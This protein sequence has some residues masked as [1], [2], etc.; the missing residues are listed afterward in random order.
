MFKRR[1][2]HNLEDDSHQDDKVRE[3]ESAIGPLSG[4]SLAFCS[5]AT[6]RRYLDARNWNVEKA[7]QMIDETLKW[8]S[9]Y[10]PHEILWSDVAHEG[11]TGKISRASFHDRYGRTVLIMRPAVQTT[12]SP[13]GNIRHLVYLLENAIIN[14]P[15]GQEQ[16]SLL[17]DFTGWTIANRSPMK[18][19]RETIHILQSHYP[20]RLGI[21]FF[22][23]PPRLFQA[24]YK[25]VKYLLDPRTAQKVNFV[26]SK[27]KASDELMRSHFDMV[28]LPKEFGGEA[29]LEYH[30]EDFS[31][32]MFEDDVKTAMFWGLD[33]IPKQATS[34]A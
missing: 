11:E 5:D 15:K 26:Y 16:I 12:T 4:H 13:E 14:L 31:R 3:L 7:K 28:N 25:A 6:L 19:T 21:S 8:R 27:D 23:N 22:Y 32:L 20:E 10:K 24:V 33:D 1:N 18:T 30:H 29:T 2:A 34:L 9:T 17:I